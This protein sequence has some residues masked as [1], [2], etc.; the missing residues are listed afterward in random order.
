LEKLAR[1]AD[2]RGAVHFSAGRFGDALAEFATAVA[3]RPQ[4]LD[5]RYNLSCAAWAA[6]DLARTCAEVQRILEQD[7][8]YSKAHDA[9]ARF[10]HES[11]ELPAA[12]AHSARAV[13]LNPAEPEFALT[14]AVIFVSSERSGEAWDALGP[15]LR[16][17]IT[18][19]RAAAIYARLA[20]VLN[21]EAQAAL[22][23]AEALV[24]PAQR[25][26][27][28]RQLHFAA[29]GLF[30]RLGRYDDAF[31]QATAAHQI[32]SKRYDPMT[33]A[34]DFEL[35][36]GHWTASKVARLARATHGSSRPV[37]IVGMP[38]SGTSLVEQI[39]GCHPQVYPA[40][41]LDAMNR[42]ARAL[43][44]SGPPYPQSLE[45]LTSQAAD[46]IAN[47]YIEYI[48]RL[49]STARYV[50]DKMPLNFIYL[51]LIAVLF[52]DCHVIHC[53]R[54]PL[55]TCLSCYMTEF[56]TPY[57][58]AEELR[59]LGLFYASYQHLMKHWRSALPLRMLQLNYEDV[60]ADLESQTR[61]I[62]EF[63]GLS[64]DERCLRFHESDRVVNTASREQVKRPIYASSVG[65]WRHYE[66]HLGPL[67][68]ALQASG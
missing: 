14:R 63:L 9:L 51:D 42:T 20:P 47:V 21:R 16:S 13:E 30:D 44:A 41:E 36:I 45:A 32:A 56:E 10:L 35:R 1:E 64:W 48:G 11:G 50:T 65:R 67:R 52:P 68:E 49:N 6:G 2:A 39:L 58:F 8:N 26:E 23:V 22:I 17:A 29:A 40:G 27:F 31:A 54:D 3:L 62:L 55:D 43:D 60:V 57:D 5:F 28:R 38:R 18:A 7:S 66:Q 25:A 33:R 53:T 61:R 15:A 34:R 24:R 19:D 59:N 37:F 12:E 46:R 4:N